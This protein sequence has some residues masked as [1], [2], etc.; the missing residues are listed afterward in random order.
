MKNRNQPG[1]ICL[2]HF[3]SGVSALLRFCK[4]VLVVVPATSSARSAGARSE[5]R[6]LFQRRPAHARTCGQRH[7]DR[8]AA[9]RAR[10]IRRHS[11]RSAGS[12]WMVMAEFSPVQLL[13]AGSSRSALTQ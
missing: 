12:I 13:P 6:Y 1:K 3:R 4:P 11:Q 7:A 10:G 2:D 9:R 5:R 8:R